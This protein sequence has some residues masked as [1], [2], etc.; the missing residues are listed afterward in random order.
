MRRLT[1]LLALL[2]SG[3]VGDEAVTVSPGTDDATEQDAADDGAIDST[4]LADA[5]ASTIVS[6][7]PD[8]AT[9][10]DA[11]DSAVGTD[12]SSDTGDS[13]ADAAD[14]SSTDGDAGADVADATDGETSVVET[15]NYVDDNG[16]G[17]VDE[18][19]TYVEQSGSR[20]LINYGSYTGVD[21]SARS[22]NGVAFT[23]W[24]HGAG[25][26]GDPH[27]VQT[28]D[29]T[30]APLGRYSFS[31]YQSSNWNS[32]AWMGDRYFVGGVT[33]NY[34]CG[35]SG[36]TSCTTYGLA[37]DVN[38][39]PLLA[40]TSLMSTTPC[41]SGFFT[42]GSEFYVAVSPG[43]STSAAVTVRSFQNTGAAG[44]VNKTLYTPGSGE[45]LSMFR[46]VGTATEIY[47]LYTSTISGASSLRMLVSDLTGAL[48]RGPFTL[49]TGSIGIGAGSPMAYV[50]GTTIYLSYADASGWNVGRWSVTTGAAIGAPTLLLAGNS[51]GPRTIDS[52]GF[53]LYVDGVG[54]SGP[55]FA[56]LSL[57]TGAIVQAPTV[58][59]VPALGTA[60]G[61]SALAAV[62]H[63]V[64][65][66]AGDY[67]G[68]HIAWAR[69]GCP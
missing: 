47:W 33:R 11:A 12:S 7:A 53:Q 21:G 59:L 57:A 16:N 2:L 30:G 15:C 20:T 18:G 19:F 27:Y 22:P 44:S 68:G 62:P 52:D 40:Q 32:P 50:G 6:D 31:A 3:C 37:V 69:F 56:R 65:V 67:G 48:V 43:C 5:D 28:V 42:A 49:A 17:L 54:T 41:V 38:A 14:A 36:S 23:W 29:L 66:A 35:G 51:T 26:P 46:G 8:A 34:D 60:Q 45:T 39:L 10:G 13:A 61:Y 55:V 1:W 64:I 25:T 9:D 24:G 63:G 58:V 4:V